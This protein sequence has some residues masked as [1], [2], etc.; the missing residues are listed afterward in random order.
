MI[1]VIGLHKRFQGVANPASAGE[2]FAMSVIR[3]L[4]EEIAPMKPNT[5]GLCL[6]VRA[7]NARAIRFYEKAGFIADPAGPTGRDAGAPHL[8]MRR[9]L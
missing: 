4:G 8:T 9:P 6:W 1:Y 3:F 2:T 7:D 5:V